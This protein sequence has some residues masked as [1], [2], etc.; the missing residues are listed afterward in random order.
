[1]AFT[2]ILE[3]DCETD[4][5]FRIGETIHVRVLTIGGHR[6]RLGIEAPYETPI[7]R[8][9]LLIADRMADPSSPKREHRQRTVPPRDQN[10]GA[11]RQPETRQVDARADADAEPAFLEDMMMDLP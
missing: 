6:V 3:L 4:E 8:E 9:E 1:M 5:Q 11:D 10:G 2:T 7:V